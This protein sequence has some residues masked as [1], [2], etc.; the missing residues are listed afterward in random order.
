MKPEETFQFIATAN[1]WKEKDR[2]LI[3]RA[4]IET[5]IWMRKLDPYLSDKSYFPFN[6]WNNRYAYIILHQETEKAIGICIVSNA[7]N[8]NNFIEVLAVD[9]NYRHLGAGVFLVE[10]MLKFQRKHWTPL[11]LSVHSTSSINSIWKKTGFSYNKDTNT[12][13]YP[14]RETQEQSQVEGNYGILEIYNCQS[15]EVFTKDKPWASFPLNKNSKG[16]WIKPIIMPI[17]YDWCI[18]WIKQG[19]LLE[20]STLCRFSMQDRYLDDLLCIR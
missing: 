16:E 18:R 7:D 1:A 10:C 11:C 8:D 14:M 4:E 15:W 13:Y 3:S 17:P 6:L 9:P 20:E 19:Q 5:E 12:Y 2:E